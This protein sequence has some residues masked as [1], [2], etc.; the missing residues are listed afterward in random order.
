VPRGGVADREAEVVD[1]TGPQR[2]MLGGFLSG[3]CRLPVVTAPAIGEYGQDGYWR[4]ER[5]R[6][7]DR[8]DLASRLVEELAGLGVEQIVLIGPS[9]LPT[10]R[11]GLRPLPVGVRG[12]LGELV[13]S[14]E[15]SALSEA[16]A[17][18]VGRCGS[19]FV[20]RPDHNPVG[21]FDFAGVY[22]EAS[23]RQRTVAELMQQGYADAYHYLIEPMAAATEVPELS[24]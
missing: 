17:V 3:A 16:T 2:D 1:F 10:R 8:P 5:P 23:D 20:V 19:V 21:P 7:C 24:E 13:R 15:S 18:A 12:R 4:G 14:L 9:P 6:V 11:H 22:D